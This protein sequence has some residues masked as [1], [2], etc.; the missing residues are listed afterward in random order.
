[1]LY[2]LDFYVID[3]LIFSTDARCDAL[4]SIGAA[5]DSTQGTKSAYFNVIC[6]KCRYTEFVD[7]QK[8]QI[9]HRHHCDTRMV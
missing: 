4:T 9:P 5:Y 8:E 6:P 7:I 1:M 2:I 3:K